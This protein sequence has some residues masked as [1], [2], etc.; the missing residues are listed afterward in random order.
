MTEHSLETAIG[1]LSTCLYLD[2]DKGAYWTSVPRRD[3]E[4][5]VE[6]AKIKFREEDR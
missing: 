4:T 6:F 2:R 3:L 1:N 5:V